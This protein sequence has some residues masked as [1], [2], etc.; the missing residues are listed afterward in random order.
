MIA[1]VLQVLA[2]RRFETLPFFN[3]QQFI[4]DSLTFI[5]LFSA[6]LIILAVERNIQVAKELFFAPLGLVN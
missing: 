5:L 6:R 1:N 2:G 3:L 4:F